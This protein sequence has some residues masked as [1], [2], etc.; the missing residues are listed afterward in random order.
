MKA[1]AFLTTLITGLILV[2]C[3]TNLEASNVRLSTFTSTPQSEAVGCNQLHAESLGFVHTVS[4]IRHGSHG[5]Q[6]R[7]TVSEISNSWS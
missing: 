5:Q 4:G 3:T 7:R 1:Q 2:C 6:C